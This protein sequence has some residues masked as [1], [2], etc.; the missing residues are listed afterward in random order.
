MQDPH[1]KRVA[2]DGVGNYNVSTVWLGLDH[3]YGEGPP[4]IFETMVFPDDSFVDS[5][6]ERYSTETEALDGHERI[7][8]NL[9]A[10]LTPSGEPI[11]YEDP[12]E[13]F[14][15]PGLLQ[16]PKPYEVGE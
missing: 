7:V 5:F 14:A 3:Q 15:P 10:G 13:L 2:L 4:L 8:A 11:K 6:C 16:L 9:R 12:N 1:Y